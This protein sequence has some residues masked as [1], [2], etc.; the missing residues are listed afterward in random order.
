[1]VYRPP[2]SETEYSKFIARLHP[3]IKNFKGTRGDVLVIMPEFAPELL[4]RCV[5]KYKRDKSGFYSA[6]RM[7]VIGCIIYHT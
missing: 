1:M 2:I 3:A 7:K 6:F 4:K 5:A